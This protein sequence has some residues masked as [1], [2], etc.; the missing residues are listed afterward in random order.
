MAGPE[1]S[2]DYGQQLT[3]GQDGTG[4]HECLHP[5][6]AT[7]GHALRSCPPEQ[8]VSDGPRGSK[9]MKITENVDSVT[10]LSFIN[11]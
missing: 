8:G 10:T 2:N 1:L 9:E 4:T 3:E 5:I 7:A 6:S 11:M